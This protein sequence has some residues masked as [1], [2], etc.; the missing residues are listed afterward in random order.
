MILEVVPAVCG[1]SIYLGHH[2]LS[3]PSYTSIIDEEA[4][5]LSP[6]EFLTNA[7]AVNTVDLSGLFLAVPVPKKNLAFVRH[8]ADGRAIGIGAVTGG[9]DQR[10][11]RTELFMR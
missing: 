7:P 1:G 3:L 9:E 10:F 6:A 8:F 11:V 5:H 4:S 2:I